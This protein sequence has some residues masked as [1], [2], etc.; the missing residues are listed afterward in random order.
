MP[1]TSEERRVRKIT[2]N[3]VTG[4]I[5]TI[6]VQTGERI[7]Q[8][9]GTECYLSLQRTLGPCLVVRSSKHRKGDGTFFLLQNIHKIFSSFVHQGKLAVIVRHGGAGSMVT[10]HIQTTHDVEELWAMLST[11]QNRTKW[12]TIEKNVGGLQ[13]GKRG[14]GGALESSIRDPAVMTMSSSTTSSIMDKEDGEDDRELP[15]SDRGSPHRR[16]EESIP[17]SE[18]MDEK[19]SSTT[20]ASSSVLLSGAL[21]W[22]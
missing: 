18:D 6:S 11:L 17:R 16:T 13:G 5:L 20:P 19:N 7:G 8:W 2:P 12:A 1:V 4:K 3:A 14:R 22:E 9:G 10:V 21:P 15:F